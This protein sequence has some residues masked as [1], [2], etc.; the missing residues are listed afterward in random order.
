[1]CTRFYCLKI[2]S[3]DRTSVN[4]VMNCRVPLKREFLN[5]ISSCK[6]SLETQYHGDDICYAQND[7]HVYS[8]LLSVP[9]SDT[10]V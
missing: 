9:H 7:T 10:S 4:K 1:M 2:G 5:Q 6:F 3:N 8:L